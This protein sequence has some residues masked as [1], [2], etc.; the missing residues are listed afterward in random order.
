MAKLG[1]DV[2]TEEINIDEDDS[3]M[4]PAGAAETCVSVQCQKQIKGRI[5]CLPEHV[6]DSS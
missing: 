5:P 2:I 4:D 1:T 6:S 3:A